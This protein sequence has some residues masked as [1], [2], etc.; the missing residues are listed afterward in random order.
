MFLILVT[1]VKKGLSD[2][3]DESG[4]APIHPFQTH[5][6]YVAPCVGQ[7]ANSG[8][9]IQ[10]TERPERNSDNDEIVTEHEV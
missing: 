4:H 10:T 9:E 1:E 2:R 3:V 7:G 6:P 8:T 5:G